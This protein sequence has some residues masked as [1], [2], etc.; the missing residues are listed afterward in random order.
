MVEPRCVHLVAGKHM[1]RYMRGI[2]DY[3]LRYVAD[4]QFILMG[5]TSSNWVGSVIDRK[6]T[7]GCCFNLG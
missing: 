7:S 4:C 2:V 1:L 6:S 3:G 5:Y